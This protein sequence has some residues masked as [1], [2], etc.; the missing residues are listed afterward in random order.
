M[1][2]QDQVEPLKEGTYVKIL[3]SNYHCVQV[4]EYRGPL[5]PKGAR[6]YRLL[7]DLVERKPRPVY[8][9]VLEEQLEVLPEPTLRELTN[10]SRRSVRVSL[11]PELLQLVQS[12]VE[13]G[14]Y[15]N[16]SEVI[17]EAIRLMDLNTQLL[18]KLKLAGLKEALAEG[19]HQAKSGE[20]EPYCLQELLT[21]LNESK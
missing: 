9:K 7:V 5:G 2:T 12:K 3:R 19:I 6:V 16:A 14:L 13:S 17:R 4:A 21:S 15:N 10:P 18:N 8:I 11:T 20:F 1:S